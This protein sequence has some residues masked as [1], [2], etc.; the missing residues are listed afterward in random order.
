MDSSRDVDV[1]AL[2][3]FA[4]LSGLALEADDEEEFLR[5]TARALQRYTA[6]D[7]VVLRLFRQQILTWVMA[8]GDG[9]PVLLSD[10]RWESPGAEDASA[11]PDGPFFLD[12]REERILDD[13]SVVPFA[14]KL[15]RRAEQLG[16]K[17]GYLVQAV[18]GADVCGHVLFAWRSLPELDGPRRGL[19]QRVVNFACL[20]FM[21]FGARQDTERDPMTDLLTWRGLERRWE[22]L[23]RGTRGAVLYVDVENFRTIVDRGGR[24][25]G[26]ELL[27]DA[28]RIVRRVVGEEAVTGRVGADCFVALI[29]D[30]TSDDAARLRLGVLRRFDEF[31]AAHAHPR[32]YLTVGTALWPRHG[33]DL[34]T[35]VSSAEQNTFARKR[36]RLKLTLSTE[37]D[38]AQGRVPRGFLNGWLNTSADGVLMTDADLRVIYVNPAY[39]RMTGYTMSEWLGKTPSFIAAGKTPLKVYEEMWASLNETGSWSGQVV[40]R[41]RSGK[42]W[43]SYLSIARILDRSGRLTGY[44]GIARNVTAGAHDETKMPSLAVFEDVFTKEALAY[45][46]ANAAQLHDG[47]STE[48]LDRVRDFT[49]LLV[50]AAASRGVEEFQSYEFRSAV[51]LA[52]ILHDVG[53]LAIPQSLLQKPGPLTPQEFDIVK[54]H[55]IAGRDLLQSTFLRGSSSTPPS[56]FLDTAVAIAGSHH[57]KWDG[58]GYPDGLAERDIPIE[59]RLVAIADVYDALRS[60]RPYK[61]PWSHADAVAYIESQAGKHF[62]PEL[63]DI[64]LSVRD[65]FDEAFRRLP[66]GY[67]VGTA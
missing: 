5:A 32:P 57:E 43:V 28:A 2:G 20:Q 67:R 21:L 11:A 8:A 30:A 44:V 55:T 15:R 65:E 1:D 45:A 3:L 49:Q 35:L 38:P 24:T 61:E 50:L 36:D 12:E 63:V 7:A 17:A 64:F 26:H 18:R 29:P 46:L 23:G 58:S 14:E 60:R 22:Q 53:K 51:T 13:L 40:N 34:K 62:D 37:T 59:A 39:E 31:A 41:H 47:D 16:L 42:E 6:A 9:G 4:E 56:L 33:T 54:T 25:A 27:R 10:Q 19:W 48:H 66:D 52:S